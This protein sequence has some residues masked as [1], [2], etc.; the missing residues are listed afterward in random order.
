MATDDFFGAQTEQSRVKASIVAKYFDG[1]SHV[2]AP[3]A[4]K[5]GRCIQYIDLFSGPG[6]YEDGSE[7]TPLLV[8]RKAIAKPKVHDLLI[9]VFNDADPANAAAL[10]QAIDELPGIGALK[11][12]PEVC[13]TPVDDQVT[14]LY[15]ATAGVPTLTFIDPFGYKGLSM[16]LVQASLKGWGCDCIFFFNFRR[17]NAAIDND[18]MEGHI[19][20]L[21]STDDARRLRQQ[22]EGLP[23]QDREAKVAQ[24]LVRALKGK[25]DGHAGK[26]AT[27]YVLQFAF[28]T[29]SGSRTSHY[30]VFATKH[31]R[32]YSIMK[33]IMAKESSWAEGGVPSY[34]CSPAPRERLLWDDLDDPLADLEQELAEAFAG[35]ALTVTKVYELHGVGR[36]YTLANY[37][38]VLRRLEAKGAITAS[39]P[40]AE[41]PPN[42]MGDGVVIQFPPLTT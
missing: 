33:D 35:Q 39:P 1:W 3:I 17:V 2:M 9:C 40:A 37:K 5:E 29:D 13:S 8:L 20:A 34:I 41:R 28:K 27:R 14:R 6:K 30:L 7:S 36:P 18:F 19:K 32:G 38:E 24:E 26:G 31:P 23:P 21:F 42:T 16:R 15:E 4:R 10:R 11:H 12:R 22:L 25:Q